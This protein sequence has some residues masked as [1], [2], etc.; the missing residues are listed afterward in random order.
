M[1]A[2]FNEAPIKF[3]LVH[4][5]YT[6]NPYLIHYLLENK[7]TWETQVCAELNWH[8]SLYV[9]HPKGRVLTLWWKPKMKKLKHSPSKSVRPVRNI[10]ITNVFLALRTIHF[11]LWRTPLK[12]VQCLSALSLCNYQGAMCSF[13]IRDIIDIDNMQSEHTSI[14]P[15]S[16]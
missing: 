13:C 11:R 5:L 14:C 8:H 9:W 6:V 1:G 15:S 2:T 12:Y 16:L 10:I 3:F 7:E 4:F